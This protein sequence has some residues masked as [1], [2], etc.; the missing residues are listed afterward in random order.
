MMRVLTVPAARTAPS[1]VSR[2]AALLLAAFGVATLALASSASGA[3]AFSAKFT[4]CPGS[5]RFEL[6]DVP[7]ATA[8]LSFAMT[9]LNVPTF[10]HGGGTVPYAGATYSAPVVPC[11]SF[12]VNFIGPS[13][14]AGQVHTYRFTIKALGADG[15]VLATTTA[16][17]KFPDR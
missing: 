15:A 14:P 5:P 8:K 16:R 1:T 10:H 6:A 12:A 4:W 7:A 2:A 17:R 13:P 11:G 3:A 9:D